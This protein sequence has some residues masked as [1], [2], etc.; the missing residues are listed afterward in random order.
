MY[1]AIEMKKIMM[2][3]AE[4]KNAGKPN[5]SEYNTLMELKKSFPDFQIEIAKSSTKKADR[6]KG[7]D[8][9]YM[10]K[11]IEDHDKTKLE[12]FYELRGLDKDGKKVEIAIAA[13]FGE[14]KMWFLAEFPEIEEMSENVNRIIEAARQKRSERKAA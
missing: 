13:S 12:T 14:I 6:F 8:Y 2:T 3:K 10:K 1:A 7:L 11:Y 9:D 5:T 4:S